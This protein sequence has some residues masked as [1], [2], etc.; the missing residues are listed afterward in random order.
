MDFYEKHF[1]KIFIYR[2]LEKDLLGKKCLTQPVQWDF[3][4]KIKR[5]INV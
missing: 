1:L 3:S 4:T 2:L 5:K